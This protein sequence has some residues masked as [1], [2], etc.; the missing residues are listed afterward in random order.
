MDVERSLDVRKHPQVL[1]VVGNRA[2]L[3]S[4]H[5]VV[6]KVPGARGRGTGEK[7]VEYG[8]TEEPFFLWKENAQPMLWP[9]GSQWVMA[10]SD[11]SDA[12]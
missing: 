11:R 3:S 2:G 6:G 4:H 5:I 8:H 10:D 9:Y 1:Q 7:A 12:S